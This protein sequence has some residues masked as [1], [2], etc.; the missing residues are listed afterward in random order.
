M[1]KFNVS[2]LA[3][4]VRAAVL[5]AA[6]AVAPAAHA[7][8]YWDA[9]SNLGG[10][11]T[12][13]VATT[14]VWSTT[15]AAGAPNSTWTPNDGTQDAAFNG[16]ATGAAS[17]T[18]TIPGG[19]TINAN[20]L[21]FGIPV[22]NVRIEGGTAL[23]ISSPTNSIVMNTNTSGSARTQIIKSAISGTD[24]TVVVPFAPG[25]NSF[26]TLGANPTGATNTFT[27]DLIFAGGNTSILGSRHQIAIDNPTALPATATVR[28]KRNICQL[29][30]GGGGGGQTTGYTA[31]F[32]NN[33][34][35]NDGGSG[36]FTQGIG[37]FAPAS[38][39]TLGGV[40]SGDANL[41]FE[42]GAGGGNGTIV[43]ANNATYTGNT[44]INS[45]T[46]AVIR[47]GVDNALPVG[48][49]FIVNRANS[50]DM[51]SF[52]QRVGGLTTTGANAADITNTGGTQSTFT[53]DGNVNGSY[54]GNIKTDIALVLAPTNTGRLTLTR[55]VGSDYT[56]GTTI[57]GGKL[58]A[59]GN[60]A[61][62]ST[63]TGPV[64]V[65]NGGTLGGNGGAG[66]AGTGTITVASGGHIA[67][68]LATGVMIGTLTSQGDMSLASGSRLDMDLGAPAPAGG[69]SDRVDLANSSLL[70]V[71][72]TA[73]SIGV[74]LSDPAGGAAGNGT[75][76]VLSFAAGSYT[77]SPNASQFFTSGQPSPNSLNGATITY[78][79]A[80][81]S[82]V[83]Q[84]GNPSL[85]TR[86]NM[87]VSGGP[88]ALLWTGAASGTWDV[89]PPNNFNNLGAGGSTTFAGNDNVTF[90]DTGANTNPI[91]VAAGGVQPNIVTIN[92]STTPYSFSGGDIKGS[93]LGG[94]GGLFLGGTGAVTI[95]S[96]YTAVGPI[97]SNKTSTGAATFN[98]TITAAT[99][100][101]VNGGAVTLAGANTYTGDNTINGGSLTASGASATFGG[102]DVTV[103]AG[104]AAISA[105]VANAILNSATLTLLGGGTANMADA[106]FISLAAGINEQVAALVLGATTQ[107]AGT[108]GATGS[109]AT[110][111]NDEYFSGLGVITVASA[112]LPGDFNSDGKVD[113]GDY[114]TW[115]KNNN[116]NNALA[117]DN[118]LGTPVGPA[119]YSLWRANFG[120]PPGAGSGGLGG[121][122]VPEPATL[123]L[124]GTA[125]LCCGLRKRE[126][127][128]RSR[129]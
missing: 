125:V 37:A 10:N 65:N 129:V 127:R 114:V 28:M 38:V 46:Q 45:Q 103:N 100:V 99:S 61:G 43:L 3:S 70:T 119:H 113:A 51:A 14:Q 71:P 42:L 19:T 88:N 53:I 86:V 31:T 126:P 64:A 15:N 108:Y 93:S 11:G 109:G 30:F 79:L 1:L 128:L 115:R 4:G 49:T 16:P 122:A 33:I 52:D 17:Y 73:A 107:L 66:A 82:N 5:A 78:Q 75:Y 55:T 83:N 123:V 2:F 44:Q 120:K 50:F 21:A 96:N 54:L 25:I 76:R 121:A 62:S 77:G 47:L 124:I 26:L 118:G 80:D 13:D 40:I 8:L 85:A 48:T 112:G 56:G 84:N 18:V 98:G 20:S 91:T 39:I 58:I 24:I 102:G 111:I 6:L 23:N 104:S 41:V 94:G 7:V 90:D 81:D 67:P 27:G 92:N 34:I 22:G 74:N 69:T 95:D 72:G 32:N 12:W 105:G 68:G 59:A 110:N 101:T 89:G 60:P 57:G 36:T 116:T 9:D 106:G 35:L 63:G 117:N 87:I 97:V 29:L